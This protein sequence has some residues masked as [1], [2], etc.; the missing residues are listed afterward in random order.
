MNKNLFKIA[1]ALC[2]T[3]TLA[4]CA[5]EVMNQE[6]PESNSELSIYTRG[7][8]DKVIVTPVRVYVF[9]SDDDCVAMQ[10]LESSGNSFTLSLPEGAYGIYAI[11]GADPER[12]V[13]PSQDDASKTSVISLQTNQSFGDLMMAHGNVTLTANGT[14]ALTLGMERKVM[15]VESITIKNVPNDIENVSVRIAPTYE[16]ILLNGNYSGEDGSYNCTLTKQ[17]DGSTWLNSAANTYLLPSVNK[18]TISVTLGTTTYSY[19]CEETLAA[20]HKLTIEG[21]Y[22][23]SSGTPNI[24]LSGT[25]TGA[26]WGAN[27]TIRFGFNSEGSQTITDDPNNPVT[28][29]VSVPNVGD[30]YNGCYVLSVNGN[31]VTLL[32]TT[33]KDKIVNNGDSQEAMTTKINAELDNW[34]K[35]IST[36]WRLMNK[37]EAE[38]I[39]ANYTSMNNKEI[40]DVIIPSNPYFLIDN[41]IIYN[42]SPTQT[43]AVTKWSD[44]RASIFLRPV[45]TITIN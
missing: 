18:P 38:Y 45:T 6:M 15:M 17:S 14:N 34:E 5:E 35:N 39:R 4:S 40:G 25:I 32:S 43:D 26:S 36:S 24:N 41:N 29:P 8:E 7:D 31:E 19:T 2:G 12:L 1:A 9:K 10:T 23:E 30:I 44:S 20:N 42:F 13:L 33:Q 27:Q 28:P 21:T 37:D 22:V 3:M 11:G 16:S